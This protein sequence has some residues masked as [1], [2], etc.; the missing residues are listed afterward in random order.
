[1]IQEIKF[2]LNKELIQ[3]RTNPVKPVLDL[4]RKDLNVFGAKEGCREG[5]CGACT[6]LLKE[7]KASGAFY[8]ALPS[9]LLPILTEGTPR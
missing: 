1:M 8:K 4:L 9:C 3:I 2:Y 6:V 5:E 7:P